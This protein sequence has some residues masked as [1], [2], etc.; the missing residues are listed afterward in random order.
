MLQKPTHNALRAIKV[1]DFQ[2]LTSSKC[3]AFLKTE[4]V[5]DSN[6]GEGFSICD[7]YF[8]FMHCLSLV[9]TLL[10]LKA[11]EFYK[12][13]MLFAEKCRISILTGT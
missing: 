1:E 9:C 5:R 12:D 7:L 6:L 2:A 11:L 10:K 4:F 3:K 8:T 13:E